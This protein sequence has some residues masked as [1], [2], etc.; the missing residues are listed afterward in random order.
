MKKTFNLAVLPGD[1]IGPEVMREGYKILNILK[2]KCFI[3]FNIHEYDI[4]GIAIDKFGS[5]LPKSTLLG[6][7]RSNAILLGSVGG[8]KWKHFPDDEQPERGA[9]LPLRKYF[10]L[11]ANIRPSVLYSELKSLSP[12]RHT[13]IHSDINILCIR[14]L[15]GGIYFGK[16]G[17]KYNKNNKKYAFDTEKYY[18]SEIERIAHL[19]FR[20]ANTRKKKIVSIDK[21][22]VLSSSKL[23]R[24]VVDNV[25]KL[26]PHIEVSHLYI[27]NAVMQIIKN[28]SQFDI[29]L[30][31][32]LFGD[33]ISD[34]CAAITGSIGMLASASLNEKNFG[35]YEPA[36]GSAPD[37]QGKNI[38]NPIAQIL[39]IALLLRYSMGLFELSDAIYESV[40]KTLK[41]G[42]RTFDI[43]DNQND[44]ITTS[45]MGDII[46][47]TLIKEI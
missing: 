34:E 23:W 36:G 32:N 43:I 19:A 40:K 46:S 39:S 25:S 4:G 21:A 5:A 28:P 6:C 10:N 27:D 35:L 20:I 24:E 1:G 13:V 11:F 47:N 9:L 26:Y 42:Y 33:I 38:A 18:E 22:N 8:P 3:N 41:M 14:E 31:S 30:C 12:L 7:E 37:I 15:T 2:K 29:I 16:S 44:Y 45:H 17:R